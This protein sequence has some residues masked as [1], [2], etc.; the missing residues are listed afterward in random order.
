MTANGTTGTV[1]LQ[2]VADKYTFVKSGKNFIVRSKPS[3]TS[4]QQPSDEY[5]F[6]N[7][8]S[9]VERSELNEIVSSET[10][11]DLPDDFI[12]DALNRKTPELVNV[13]RH[14]LKK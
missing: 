4:A 14:R 10:A 11:I 9:T 1:T 8:D 13:T 3:L 5:W 2:D 12:N 7:E 6:L